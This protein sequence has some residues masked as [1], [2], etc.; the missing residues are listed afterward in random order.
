MSTA[1]VDGRYR[2]IPD[3]GTRVVED[4]GHSISTDGLIVGAVRA[5][6]DPD[7]VRFALGDLDRILLRSTDRARRSAENLLGPI[8]VG[9]LDLV[10]GRSCARQ[11]LQGSGLPATAAQRAL[12]TLLALG[13]VRFG[14][15]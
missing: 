7:I 6:H 15:R 12:L 13:L 5:L 3:E 1:A 10:D 14:L 8:E 2:F 9:I 11:L 4:E